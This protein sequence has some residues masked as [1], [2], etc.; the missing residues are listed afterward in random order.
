MPELLDDTTL[1]RSAVVANNA[2]N[3]ERG[4]AGVNSYARELGFDPYERLTERLRHDPT[5]T[6]TWID[7]CCGSGRALLEAETRVAQEF[8]DADV[9]LIGIDLVDYFAAGPRTPRLRLIAAS[10]TTWTPERPADLVTC[11]HGLHYLGDKLA[12]IG[13]MAEWTAPSG[14]LAADFDLDEV[15]GI[16]H[17]TVLDELRACGLT[18][19]R[20]AHRLHGAGPRTPRFS[21]TYLGADDTEGPGYTGQPSVRSYY[22]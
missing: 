22:R 19:D 7:V 10:A 11:V 15:R 13:V 3:R 16:E 6:V 12:M 1:E 2:M 8:P 21:A 14:F 17:T 9:T 5:A 20:R 18:Y 4:L